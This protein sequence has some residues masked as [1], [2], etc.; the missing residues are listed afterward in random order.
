MAET[1]EDAASQVPVEERR[2]Q[3]CHWWDFITVEPVMFLYM[4]AFMLTSVIEQSFFVDKA[5]RV[6]L[7]FSDTI[8]SN[9]TNKQYM[10]YNKQVQVIVSDFHQYNNVAT[11]AIPLV[12]ALF[13]GA[14]SDRRGRKLPL[15]LGLV[16]KLY[17]SVM[18]IVNALQDTWSL[19]VVL[20]SASLP[21]SLTGADLA[22]FAALFTYVADVT[23]VQDRTFRVTMLDITYLLTM[24]TGVALGKYL[25]SSV[26]GYSYPIMF[27]INSSLLFVAILYALW[28]LKWRTTESQQ[29]IPRNYFGDFF[30]CDHVV[31]SVKVVVRKRPGNRRVY[32][33]ILFIAMA[34]Y[35]FQ[36]D[37][38]PMSYLYTQLQ[39]QWTAETYS[40]YRTFQ[41]ASYVVG[42]ILGI[43]VMGKLMK[44]RDT[45]MVMVGSI[46]HAVTRVVF[47]VAQVPWLFYVGGTI[48]ALGPIVAPV[49][50]SM[51]SKVVPLSERGKVFAILAAADNAVPLFSGILYT[52]VY[53]ATISTAPATIFWVTFASQMCVFFLILCIHM[54]LHGGSLEDT[55]VHPLSYSNDPRDSG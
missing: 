20:L 36:R 39:F 29:P 26:A 38:K 33:V 43:H 2:R 48:V 31:Q 19:E 9:L 16:G 51:T 11:H 53:N 52:Q 22:I 54:S 50:R 17:Y 27:G 6:N 5:C 28:Q 3:R 30:D 1:K 8:C 18:I 35:T 13:L 14:W 23:T 45:T 44:M 47:A 32:L 37:E 10:D 15:L 41:N 7:N 55:F 46:A 40:D 34:L 12:L 49:L 42:T 21:S 24:P 25:W 4:M